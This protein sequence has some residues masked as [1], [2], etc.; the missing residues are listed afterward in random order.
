MKRKIAVG[1][2]GAI[3]IILLA[4]FSSVVS[5]QSTKPNE[6]RASIF[7]QIREKI[8]KSSFDPGALLY[9]IFLFISLIITSILH[10]YPD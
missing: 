5:A 4:S 6:M 1:S 7:Q 2:I 10:P 3:I 8:I 9:F